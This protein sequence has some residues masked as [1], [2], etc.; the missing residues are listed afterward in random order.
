[1]GNVFY[2]NHSRIA[3]LLWCYI[4]KDSGGGVVKICKKGRKSKTLLPLQFGLS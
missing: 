2:S 1:M 4:E 3:F